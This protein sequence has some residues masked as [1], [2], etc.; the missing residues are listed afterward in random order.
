MLIYGLLDRRRSAAAL[1][2]LLLAGC[3]GHV[4]LQHS[5]TPLQIDAAS[6]RLSEAPS[7][8]PDGAATRPSPGLLSS[9]T[10]SAADAPLHQIFAQISSVSHLNFVFDK[11]VWL[12][13]KASL[14]LTGVSVE[15]ALGDVLAAHALEYRVLDPDTI[16]VYP[17]TAAARDQYQE[18][19][20]K[21][22]FLE[23]A[24]ASTVAASLKELLKPR[25]LALDER[26]NLLIM[27]DSEA[28]VRH[29][30][31]LLATLDAPVPE[32]ELEVQLI[33]VRRQLLTSLG[34]QW[35]EQVKLL[36]ADSGRQLTLGE[37]QQSSRRQL[38]LGPATLHGQRQSNDMQVLAVHRLRAREREKASLRIGDKIPVVSVASGRDAVLTE[39]INYVDLGFKLDLEPMQVG[40]Q[41][42]ALRLSLEASNQRGHIETR[43][44]NVV[45][46]IESQRV[47]TV[48]RLQNG[49][50]QLI[51]GQRQR[52]RSEH[53]QDLPFIGDV[54]PLRHLAGDQERTV[55]SRELLIAITPRLIRPPVAATAAQMQYA[56]G[57]GDDWRTR[58]QRPLAPNRMPT[59][60]LAGPLNATPDPK[61]ELALPMQPP[62]QPAPATAVTSLQWQA[63]GSVN[64]G[65]S[66]TVALQVKPGEAIDS[67]QLALQFDPRIFEVKEVVEGDFLRQGLAATRYDSNIDTEGH[68]MVLGR[69]NAPNQGAADKEGVLVSLQMRALAPS[70]ASR[71]AVLMAGPATTGGT[72]IGVSVPAPHTLRVQAVPSP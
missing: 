3:S 13:Q 1:L 56:A 32:V 63:P 20:I 44:G 31:R 10:L 28:K 60:H 70:E 29:A 61:P 23:H 59:A 33:E 50:N 15:Q 34:I 68:V 52:R 30:E 43:S 17:N 40:V 4:P 46:Q 62:P 9:V 22:F 66:F 71:L 14:H 65:D 38:S 51:A 21:V 8:L 2:A 58:P 11:E 41:D 67:F 16:F 7:A 36:L 53:G 57:A 25:S 37:L 64:V 12:E 39:S 48:L 49:Q 42:V 47:S 45:P 18:T 19:L 54:P 26:L 27:R 69:R 5:S 72:P 35:P 6:P 24:A 55:D